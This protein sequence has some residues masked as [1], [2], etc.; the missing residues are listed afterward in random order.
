M[1]PKVKVSGVGRALGENILTNA[2]L[3]TMV[4]TTD[5]W[6][7]E[8]TGIRERRIANPDTYT[9]DLA[10][11][12]ACEALEKAHIK[13]C[14]LDMI[15]VA[16]V[17][18]DS[19]V[20]SMSC[21]L[22]ARLGAEKAA[23]YDMNMA[24]TGFVAGFI[25]AQQFIENGTY[26][27]VLLVGADALSKV[28]D[29]TD[30][31]TCILFGDGAGAAVLSA[32]DDPKDPSAVLASELSA[33]GADGDRLTLPFCKTTKEEQEKRLTNHPYVLW[34]DGGAVMKYAVRVMAAMTKKTLEK[35]HVSLTELSLL[36]PHQANR[37]IIDSAVKRI[38]ISD[39]RVFVNIE[40]YGN[41]SSACI[42]IAL[43][44][45]V[46]EE[47]IHRGDIIAMVGFGGGLTAGCL[48]IT[49]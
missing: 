48:V 46:K 11:R 37:R 2:D 35:A 43:Y 44:E 17:T 5:A 20:P 1:K 12:A 33:D 28:T 31:Q 16:S 8:R 9:G 6:I 38:G 25:L 40:K 18:P 29:Y 23:C 3:E 27:H 26:R 36:I 19:I 14:E 34:M 42:P 30:R 21:V 10:Y 22:Q 15:V 7:V 32:N 13:A 47:R 4:D 41:M 49:W 45:A 39:R 24:C